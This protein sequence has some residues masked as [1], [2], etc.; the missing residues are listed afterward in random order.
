M[1]IKII[2]NITPTPKKILFLLVYALPSFFVYVC[3]YICMGILYGKWNYKNIFVAYFLKFN[4]VMATRLFSVS[5][6]TV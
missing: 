1:F 2:C 6:N 4:N 5:V 3:V